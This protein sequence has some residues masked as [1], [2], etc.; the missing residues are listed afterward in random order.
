MSTISRYIFKDTVKTQFAIFAVLMLIFMSQTF[1]RF[2]SRAVRGSIPT[3]LVTQL[4]S[5]SIP[6][7]ANFMLP[8]S[9][10]LAVLFTI[11]SLCSQSEMVV[12]RSVGYSRMRLLT[13]VFFLALVTALLNASCSL[14][15]A[16]W[17]EA[18]QLE[19]INKAKSDPSVMSF[20]SGKFINLMNSTIYIDE[21]P[22]GNGYSNVNAQL[23]KDIYIF[24]KGDSNRQIGSTVTLSSEGAIKYDKDDLMWLTLKNGIS[25]EEQVLAH[26]QRIST[27]DRY[28]I[29][30][31]EA[32]DVSGK[33]KV[34]AKSTKELFN[35]KTKA[36][37]A[38]LEWRIVQPI[39]IFV[40]V[41]LVV[42]LSMVNPRQGRFAKF[43][44]AICIYISYYLFA[45]GLKS[46]I[47]R[48]NFEL[49]P[50]IF[51]VPVLYTLVFTIPLN[52]MD[53]EFVS[54]L[55]AKKTGAKNV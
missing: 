55:L 26:K 32:T 27:F 16:P 9:L 40:L 10:F 35:A 48:E 51:L 6:T 31:P 49:F 20:E 34:S 45:F 47:A 4:L 8:L 53:T 28:D 17:S 41:L 21:D 18:K 13:V 29:L 43:L 1:I 25:Y 15:L 23:G 38:E 33:E 44:P 12:M 54:R 3:E 7:M 24:Q 5:L 2:V 39:S 11:G 50:G 14:F 36:E 30:V 22:E 19:L 37:M 46:S 42:P 52:L